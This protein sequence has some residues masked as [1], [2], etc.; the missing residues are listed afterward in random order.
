MR[1]SSRFRLSSLFLSPVF[2]AALAWA[3]TDPAWQKAVEH[4]R[5]LKS[6]TSSV[7]LR[8]VDGQGSAV[9][10][11]KEQVWDMAYQAPGHLYIDTEQIRLT[12]DGSKTLFVMEN[13][14]G[15]AL[16]DAPETFSRAA[17][18]EENP[19][20]SLVLRP[21][22]LLTAFDAGAG[23]LAVA[24][25]KEVEWDGIKAV[26][27]RFSPGG[28]PFEMILDPQSGRILASRFDI[29]KGQGVVFQLSYGDMEEN[30]AVAPPKLSMTPPEGY[31]DITR[32]IANQMKDPVKELAGKPAPD[33]TLKTIEG[34]EVTLSK[35][36][37]KVVVLDFWAT[38]CG[39]CRKSIPKIQ[40]LA[41]ELKDR[42]VVFLAMNTDHDDP[43]G[44]TANQKVKSFVQDNKLTLK[45]VM[46]GESDTSLDY[47]ANSIPMTVIIGPD[48]EILNVFV[49][50]LPGM[51]G[52][53]RKE[54]GEAF[55]PPI[56]FTPA[57]GS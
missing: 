41:E 31:Q 17:F 40:A 56:V 44:E 13:E 23:D 26:N 48:G 20:Y 21:V 25:S 2:L 5:G 38:W 10:G 49:G 11:T 57:S 32:Q 8:V 29:S 22:G 52:E 45:Q 53:I 28:D 42:D 14:K 27:I 35:L 4:Y 37:G 36:R 50:Y 3:G 19:V 54:I 30:A 18:V 34:E 24:T 1:H 12:S 9:P 55:K 33:F 47:I 15:Y 39:P 43:E 16:L 7:T 51:E 46:V 6:F